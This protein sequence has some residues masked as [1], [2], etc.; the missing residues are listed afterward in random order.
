MADA[1]VYPPSPDFVQQAHVQGMEG[2]RDLYDRPR[3]QPEEFWGEIAERELHWF[4]KWSKVLEWNPPFAK[5]FAGAKINVSYN[6]LDRHLTTPRK[7]KVAILW[8]GEPGDQRMITYQELHRLV[9][10]FANV[11]KVAR[12]QG[13]RPRHHLHADDPRAAHRHAGL[14]ASRHHPQRRVRRILGRGAEGPHPGPRARRSSS[15]PMAACAAARKSSSSPPSMRRSTNVP[16]CATSSS[17]AA[18]VRHVRMKEGRD[19]WWHELDEGATEDCPAVPLDSEHP[20]FVLYTS[21]T[22]GKPKGIL[23]TTGGYLPHAT[24]P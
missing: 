17:I 6:C 1:N 7:N 3:T 12:L 11:L 20:L 5:W 18:P 22:T 13:R 10:R 16:A 19:L 8:E 23:H 21:G 24:R 4:E 14:H 2:Y 9:V 15:P